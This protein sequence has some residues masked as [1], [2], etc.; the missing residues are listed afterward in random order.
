[1]TTR[2]MR[3]IDDCGGID[4]YLLQLDERLVSDSNYIMKI[5]ELIANTLY[6]KNQLPEKFI[7]KMDYHKYPPTQYKIEFNKLDGKYGKWHAY[8][9]ELDG[10]GLDDQDQGDLLFESED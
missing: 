4:Q 7:K 9:L 3:A 10:E 1:M 6:H 2:A 8:E 5:R